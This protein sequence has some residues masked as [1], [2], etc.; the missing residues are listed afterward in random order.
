MH[1]NFGCLCQSG[2]A[3]FYTKTEAG[4]QHCRCTRAVPSTLEEGLKLDVSFNP[5]TAAAELAVVSGRA[6]A[7]RVKL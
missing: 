7:V 3:N 2:E 4:R 1:P 5:P 6:A